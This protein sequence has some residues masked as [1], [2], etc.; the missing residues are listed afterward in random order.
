MEKYLR[1][2]FRANTQPAPSDP[3]TI[4]VGPYRK[5]VRVKDYVRRVLIGA[6]PLVAW[7]DRIAPHPVTGAPTTL[8]TRRFIAG[9]TILSLEEVTWDVAVGG[10]RPSLAAALDPAWR[11]VD[12]VADGAAGTLRVRTD[13]LA[14][15]LRV[16]KGT[17]LPIA[18]H[19]ENGARVVYLNADQS[20]LYD[21]DARAVFEHGQR[22]GGAPQLDEEDRA[23]MGEDATS[24]D[25]EDGDDDEDGE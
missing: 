24:R 15:L 17:V 11:L 4:V 10:P 8:R 1:V 23:A 19:P 7:D 21:L 14:D 22:V 6:E 25:D 9:P 20:R 13:E 12:H 3:T 16:P 5:L 2:T 18:R